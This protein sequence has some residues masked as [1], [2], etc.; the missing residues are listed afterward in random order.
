MRFWDSSA[1]I[2]LLLE[3]PHSRLIRALASADG[4]IAAWWGSPV[5]C[6][7]AVGRLRREGRITVRDEDEIRGALDALAGCW[8]EIEPT[9]ELRGA[10]ARLVLN[11]PLRAADALQLAAALAWSRGSGTGHGFVCLDERLRLAAR[12][13]GFSVLP[14]FP[15]GEN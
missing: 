10:A 6:C 9:A 14:D 3:E 13:E 12:N 8:T 5:E 2:P 7:S 4:S 1:M 15:D 11:H